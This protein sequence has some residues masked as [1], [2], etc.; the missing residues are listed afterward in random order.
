MDI[1][2]NIV[3]VESMGQAYRHSRTTVSLINYHF[4]W[5]PRRRR[6][7]LVGAVAKRLDGLIREVAKTLDFTIVA[8]EIMPDHV[9]L[10]VSASPRWA[11]HQIMHRIKGYTSHVLRSEYPAL[12]KL[13]SMWT[14]SYWCSTAGNVSSETIR[15]YIEEQTKRGR[16]S[17]G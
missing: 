5:I 6:P 17:H 16:S 7:V 14:R 12:L 2:T 13:P 9:H 1:A 3:Y 4:V 15:R 8:L 11:P 10:F